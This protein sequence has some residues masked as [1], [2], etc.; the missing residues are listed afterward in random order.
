M[1]AWITPL[2]W[3]V[4]WKPTSLSLSRTRS[5]RSGCRRLSSRAT[6]R[7]TIPA[8]TTARS[9]S[10]AGLASRI[11]GPGSITARFAIISAM[12][13]SDEEVLFAYDLGSPY[14]W[15]AAE[16]IDD[17]LPARPT[18][19]PVLL[20]A[21]FKA[22][23]RSSW[24]Q[25]PKRDEGMAEIERRA[26]ERGLGELR[27]PDPWPNDGL[28][29][30]RAAVRAHQL[31]AGERFAIA[32]L[33]TH[34]RDGLALSDDASITTAAERADLD[35]GALLAATADPG[36]KAELR[37]NTERAL[38]LGVFGVPTVVVRSQVFWGDDQL[39]GPQR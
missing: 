6:A 5:E 39:E 16:R 8:P 22:K 37:A 26:A 20:G 29:V 4:W 19:L 27:W 31:G 36:V 12:P 23:G 35:P 9:H 32:A 18:W 3:P 30:M 34:F 7:P 10:P 25:G 14:A 2:L 11:I 1:P 24:G 38:E 28:R 33:R 15:L 13:A 17:V 21:I